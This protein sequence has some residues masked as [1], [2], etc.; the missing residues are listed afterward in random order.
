MENSNQVNHHVNQPPLSYLDWT[1][2]GTAS[3]TTD[4]AIAQ[5][6]LVDHRDIPKPGSSSEQ[7]CWKDSRE[8]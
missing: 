5:F 8:S 2:K 6:C 7:D 4:H 3:Q 1:D